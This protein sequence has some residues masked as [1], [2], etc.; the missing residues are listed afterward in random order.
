MLDG[1][2]NRLASFDW[3]TLLPLLAQGDG[4]KAPPANDPGLFGSLGIWAPLIVIGVLFYFML[5]RP[6][7]RERAQVQKLLESLKKNDRVLL[8]SG[9]VGS[10]AN[11]QQGSKYVTLKIDDST[12]AKIKVLRSAIA[13]VVT[14]EDEEEE[15]KPEK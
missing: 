2:I 1:L 7:Q 4:G 14:P 3:G 9:I 10:I 8:Q 11:I 6:Q 12:N 13:R 5:I 15:K